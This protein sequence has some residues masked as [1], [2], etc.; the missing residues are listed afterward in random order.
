MKIWKR[1]GRFWIDATVCGERHREPLGTTDWREARQ[2]AKDRIA[3]LSKR[4]P[5]PARRGR[6]YAGLDVDAAIKAYAEERRAQV[7]ARMMAYWKE[8]AKPLA[9]FFKGKKLRAI[10][11]ADLAAY[12][13]ARVDAGRAPKTINGELSVLRQVL[14]YARL[15]YRLQDDY[16]ALKNTKPPAGQAL[17]DDDQRQLFQMARSEPRWM[18]AYIAAALAF[19][20]GLRACEIRGLQWKHVD[21]DRKRL[22][23]RRSKTPAGWRD[24]SLNQACLTALSELH[25]RAKELGYAEN[26][27][28]VF[29][30]H[31]RNK[32]IDP[33]KP[34]TSWRS[35]WRSLRKAAGLPYVRFHDGRHTA[36]T[37]LAEAGQ[38]DWV[39]QAQ[40]GHVSPAMMKTYSHIRRKAL[41]EAA[42]TL[43][44]T[45]EFPA[46]NTG[47]SPQSENEPDLDPVT[48]QVTSQ[49]DDLPSDIAEILKE[50]GS[51][52]W[53][54]TSN[55]PVNRRKK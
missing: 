22:Q 5:D 13:N 19:Y 6:A 31:G 23:V 1:G 27:H 15:W 20:C 4:P 37:R 28:F 12:Q 45:F 48:S 40:M 29:P 8:S 17:T 30:C 54:R 52:G 10:A 39:I 18:F 47:G 43:E 16:R 44:P 14:R 3:E 32:K 34:M 38:P 53:T 42:A 50:S 55:P 49:S 9:A 51:S 2:L 11:T 35:A 41:D 36:L 7:S 25:T 33:T 24:P 46:T 21:W 26:E